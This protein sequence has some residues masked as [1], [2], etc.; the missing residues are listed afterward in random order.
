MNCE[1]CKYSTT[2]K[3]NWDKHLSTLKH[4]QIKETSWTC[5]LCEYTTPVKDN[6]KKHMNSLLHQLLDNRN[7]TN[8]FTISLDQIDINKT[9]QGRAVILRQI[10]TLNS[11]YKFAV[12]KGIYLYVYTT[13]WTKYEPDDIL[14][15][16][17]VIY[18]HFEDYFIQKMNFET[19]V[20]YF[21]LIDDNR[22]V[23]EITGKEQQPKKREQKVAKKITKEEYTKY[24]TTIKKLN[25]LK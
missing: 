2:V 23:E 20:R 25:Q 4:T 19:K 6:F 5:N 14:S 24:I 12:I 10:H 8:Y 13:E 17:K 21:Y 11:Q 18:K 3:C 9:T 16:L 7:P 22:T 1:K 15:Q